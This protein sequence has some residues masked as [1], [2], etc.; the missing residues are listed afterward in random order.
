MTDPLGG[1]LRT[2]YDDEHE[3]FRDSVRGFL[4]R[5]AVPHLD[6]WEQER[7]IDREVW[8]RA[9]ESG[10]LGLAV[11]TELG[12]G[13][14]D[15]YRFRCVVS[16]EIARINSGSLQ[17][18]FALQDDVFLPYLLG[19]GTAEQ[20][21]RYLPA[22]CAGELIGAIA[23]TEPGTGS[24]LQGIRTTAVRD[25][26]EWVIDGTKTFITNGIHGDVVVVVART[27]P[28]AGSRGF[29]LFLVERDT[30]GFTRGE[31]LRKIGLHAQD[32]AELA[33]DGC[34]VPTGNLLGEEGRGFEHLMHHL[35]LERLS[36]VVASVAS[37]RAALRWT[38]R[39]VNERQA[40]GGPLAQ[41]QTIQ[42]SLAEMMTEIDVAQS[43]ADDAVR[44]YNAGTLTAVDAAKGKWWCTELQKRVVDR[45]VQLHGGYGY[46]EEYPIARAYLDTRVQTIYGGTTEI[47]KLIIGREVANA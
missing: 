37:A 1:R 45:C 19:L 30:P 6:R 44:A 25:G 4:E 8:A 3:A 39:Y 40:F 32:T 38:Q 2:L 12:G 18:S 20:R 22:A 29:S 13:G 5:H 43:Y 28:E 11:P 27:D 33:F 10:L 9:G 36:L 34:R 35:P 31:K 7:L 17:S 21:Q 41:Q 26:D 47:M 16:E 46:M 24:D 23:M 42:F 15:D 14:T